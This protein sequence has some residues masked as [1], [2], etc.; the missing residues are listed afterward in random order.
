MNQGIVDDVV[1]LAKANKLTDDELVDVLNTLES[2][3]L[4]ELSDEILDF[5]E[6]AKTLM[7]GDQYI[8]VNRLKSLKPDVSY[9]TSGGHL[10]NTDSLGRID[11]VTGDQI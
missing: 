1:D 10:Y 9:T 2:Q 6:A 7:D 8:K 5:K 11:N 4:P 3:N